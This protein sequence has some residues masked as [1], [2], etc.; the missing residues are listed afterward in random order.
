[1]ERKGKL[2]I[3]MTLHSFGFATECIY[4]HHYLLNLGEN[5]MESKVSST[6]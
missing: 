5:D 1:M 4:D 6:K 3:F 2:A